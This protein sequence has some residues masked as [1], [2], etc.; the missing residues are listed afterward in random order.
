MHNRE[1]KRRLPDKEFKKEITKVVQIAID[2]K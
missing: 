1:G 2:Y